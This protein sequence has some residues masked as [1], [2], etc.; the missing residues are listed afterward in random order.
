MNELFQEASLEL[1]AAMNL[2]WKRLNDSK[3]PDHKGWKD[4]KLIKQ[5]KSLTNNLKRGAK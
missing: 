1:R 5:M 3:K 4:E 2:Y